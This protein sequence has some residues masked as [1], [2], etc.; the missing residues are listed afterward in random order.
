MKEENEM[1]K[2]VLDVTTT[3]ILKGLE[4]IDKI[5]ILENG[6][7]SIQYSIT[8][9]FMKENELYY[10]DR[11]LQLDPNQ[12]NENLRVRDFANVMKGID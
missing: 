4:K 9:E 12:T 6:V 7:I 11:I 1:I 10:K 2:S 8:D 5:D 3:P